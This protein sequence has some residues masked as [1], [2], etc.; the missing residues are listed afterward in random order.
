M[1]KS[2]NI[3]TTGFRPP[4]SLEEGLERTIKYEFID[5]ITDQVFYTE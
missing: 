5:K 1:F 3:K 4:V 2:A